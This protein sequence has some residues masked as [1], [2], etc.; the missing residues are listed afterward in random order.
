MKH[1]QVK[2]TKIQSKFFSKVYTR[3]SWMKMTTDKDVVYFPESNVVDVYI[4]VFN[5]GNKSSSFRS[6]IKKLD[7]IIDTFDPYI[8]SGIKDSIETGKALELVRLEEELREVEKKEESIRKKEAEKNFNAKI[9][10]EKEEKGYKT[11]TMEVYEI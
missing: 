4:L 1:L 5:E 6:L 7:K 8:Q 2:L 10:K 3:Y 11:V 9:T